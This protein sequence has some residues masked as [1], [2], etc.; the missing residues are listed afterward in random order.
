[1]GANGDA[2]RLD[3]C[4][5]W[6]Q[7]FFDGIR[8]ISAIEYQYGDSPVEAWGGPKRG[9]VNTTGYGF[10]SYL[11]TMQHSDY[12][13]GS[14]CYCGAYSEALKAFFGPSMDFSITFPAGTTPISSNA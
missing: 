2:T 10:R 3:D 13:S 6:R 14:G 12:P 8:P 5:S 4:A 1:M 7:V 11:K 9:T